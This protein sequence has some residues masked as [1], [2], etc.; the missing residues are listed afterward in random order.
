MT[1]V[2][3][4][5][6]TV[7]RPDSDLSTAEYRELTADGHLVDEVYGRRRCVGREHDVTRHVQQVQRHKLEQQALRAPTSA[8]WC[9]NQSFIFFT[10]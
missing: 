10:M 5:L 3:T 6:F 4:L 1:I 8:A 7:Q 9:Q 2:R